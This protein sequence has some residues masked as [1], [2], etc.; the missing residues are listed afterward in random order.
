M[1]SSR[2]PTILDE[3]AA[4]PKRQGRFPASTLNFVNYYSKSFTYYIK[5]S[6]SFGIKE[7]PQFLG[8]CEQA[9]YQSP[10]CWLPVYD[11]L[12]LLRSIHSPPKNCAC[13]SFTNTEVLS[14]FSVSCSLLRVAALPE[15]QRYIYF[16]RKMGN[17]P[18]GVPAAATVGC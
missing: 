15:F 9:K 16:C 18:Q 3:E 2:N 8:I 6:F 7:S 17:S 10:I 13:R 5:P 1:P 4:Q 11:D 12:D 14:C